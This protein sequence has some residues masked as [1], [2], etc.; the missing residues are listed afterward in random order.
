MG[1][2]EGDT[3]LGQG[4]TRIV[5]LVERKTGRVRMRRVDSAEKEPSL[6][7]IVAAFN[8]IKQRVH[9]LTRDNGREF[10]GHAIIDV[11]WEATIYFVDPHSAWQRGCNENRNSVL[12]PYFPKGCDLGMF[13]DE[14]A[15]RGEDQINQRSGKRLRI[16]TPQHQFDKYVKRGALR[17]LTRRRISCGC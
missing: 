9:T 11:V 6:R 4:N 14:E 2:W 13:S 17:T 8:P 1:D 5:T 10:A 12:R 7:A 3:I 15:Q 16:Q